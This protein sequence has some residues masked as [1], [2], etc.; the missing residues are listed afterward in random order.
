MN[1]FQLYLKQLSESTT[2]HV[3]KQKPRTCL[4]CIRQI[5][6]QPTIACARTIEGSAARNSS[7]A[8]SKL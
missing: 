7:N 2:V 5:Q 3:R 1:K 8:A 6:I 4:E